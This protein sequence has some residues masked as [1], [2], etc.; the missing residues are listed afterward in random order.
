MKGKQVE[1]TG[2]DTFSVDVFNFPNSEGNIV[3]VATFRC[4]FCEE[5]LAYVNSVEG[6]LVTKDNIDEWGERM[7]DQML[8]KRCPIC[9]ESLS[10]YETEQIPSYDC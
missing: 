2:Q 10:D 1:D 7:V 5:D 9:R 8:Q 4:P 3:F 6:E